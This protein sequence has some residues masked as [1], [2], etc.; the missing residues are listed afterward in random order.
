MKT[1]IMSSLQTDSSG[2][3]VSLEQVEI[4]VDQIINEAVQAVKATDRT[5]AY[6][7]FQLDLIEHTIAKSVQQLNSHFERR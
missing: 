6:T 4:V 1:Q 2:K 3:W 7:T 5:H